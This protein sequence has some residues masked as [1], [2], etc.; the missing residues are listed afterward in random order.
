MSALD[1]PSHQRQQLIRALETGMLEAPYTEIAVRTAVGG[2]LD[3][4]SVC[5]ELARLTSKG[6][7]GAAVAYALERAAEAAARVH[8]PDLVWSGEEVQGLHARKTRQVF[9]EVV[10]GA[11]KSLWI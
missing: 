8:R 4:T 3:A 10:G 6:I 2:E 11:E 9:D 7:S 5:T 1:L